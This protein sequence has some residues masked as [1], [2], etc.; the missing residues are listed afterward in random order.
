L[1]PDRDTGLAVRTLTPAIT[2]QICIMHMSERPLE[3]AAEAFLRTLR[4]LLADAT[5]RSG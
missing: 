5:S 4:P 3:P 1:P 2:R